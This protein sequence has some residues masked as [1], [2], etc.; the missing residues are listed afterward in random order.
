MR[1]IEIRLIAG[2]GESVALR[3]KNGSQTSALA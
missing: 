2:E 3:A 1:R